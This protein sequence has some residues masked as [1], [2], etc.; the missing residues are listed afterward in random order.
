MDRGYIDEN[1]EF[2]KA[3]YDFIMEGKELDESCYPV[4][5]KTILEKVREK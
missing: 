1:K 2:D 5:F 3:Y 4:E